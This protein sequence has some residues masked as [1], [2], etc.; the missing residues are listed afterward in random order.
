MSI[1]EIR[2]HI[3]VE[4]PSLPRTSEPLLT[5]TLQEAAHGLYS[6]LWFTKNLFPNTNMGRQV[7]LFLFPWI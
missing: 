7:A 5:E 3:Y 4:L 6:L 1:K 2:A